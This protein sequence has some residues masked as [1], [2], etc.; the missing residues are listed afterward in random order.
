MNKPTTTPE[1]ERLLNKF[2]ELFPKD[3]EAVDGV[4]K[5]KSNRS[6]ALVLLAEFDRFL[7]SERKHLSGLVEG[8]SGFN[9][10]GKEMQEGVLVER[11]KVIEIINH[12]EE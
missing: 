12:K 7:S 9:Y 4:R 1:W 6:A 8:I 11:H 5:S 2:E 3:Q 10:E